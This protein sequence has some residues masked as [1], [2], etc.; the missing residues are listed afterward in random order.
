[1]DI[2]SSINPNEY[3]R[4]D[5]ILK[6]YIVIKVVALID[7]DKHTFS[8][9]HLKNNQ[10]NTLLQKY[11]EMLK[12][13]KKNRDKAFSHHEKHFIENEEIM[14]TDDLFDLPLIDFLD[15]VEKEL[16]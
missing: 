3:G 7:K 5:R 8:L 11:S 4:L 15:E 16:K 13:M 9:L 10:I 2:K 14:H 1:M 12:T 6:E